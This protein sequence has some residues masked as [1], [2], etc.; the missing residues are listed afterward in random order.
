[1]LVF[2]NLNDL[3]AGDKLISSIIVPCRVPKKSN[4]IFATSSVSIALVFSASGSKSNVSKKGLL[5]IPGFIKQTRTPAGPASFRNA[6]ANPLK[7]NFA[8]SDWLISHAGQPSHEMSE[9]IKAEGLDFA[10]ASPGEYQEAFS[11]AGF[12]D[13]ELVN[14]NPWYSSIAAKELEW[15]K[16]PEREGLSIRHGKEFIDHQVEIWEKL[17][18]VLKSGE[19]CP[20]HIRAKKP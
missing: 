4:T 3:D 8:A 1:M 16:G 11:K 6:C 9:Y 15:L 12:V 7:P 10:M 2:L 14:R 19:H 20:H 18:G 5:T 13:V 17:V